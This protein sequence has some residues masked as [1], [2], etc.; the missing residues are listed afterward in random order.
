M[1]R[2]VTVVVLAGLALLAARPPLAP[3]A[4]QGPAGYDRTPAGAS[5]TPAFPRQPAPW[6]APNPARPGAAI[7]LTLSLPEPDWV[8]F[9]VFDVNGRRVAARPLERMEAGRITRTWEP[10]LQRPGLYLVRCWIGSG[11]TA[12]A[13]LVIVK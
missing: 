12:A 7:V 5:A 11:A 3:G 13:R 4:T 1:V 2:L 8:A 9:E 10:G 6:L